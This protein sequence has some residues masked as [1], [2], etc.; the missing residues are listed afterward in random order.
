M[1]ISLS[2]DDLC[3]WADMP[4]HRWLLEWIGWPQGK[5]RHGNARQD[6]RQL[7]VVLL[8]C[9]VFVVA[10]TFIPLSEP[11]GRPLQ[12]SPSTTRPIA[13]SSHVDIRPPSAKAGRA[14]VASPE[15]R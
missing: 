1:G 15:G 5:P 14:S 11:P 13:E 8:T 9:S 6:V 10:L 12:H 4:S 7:L 3:F 2:D